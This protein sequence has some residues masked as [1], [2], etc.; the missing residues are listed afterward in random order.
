MIDIQAIR[1]RVNKA[2]RGQWVA[3]GIGSE[4]YNIRVNIHGNLKERYDA[5]G[6]SGRI[7]ETRSGRDWQE[8]RANAEFIVHARED[9]PNAL[10]EIERLRDAL[11]FYANEEKHWRSHYDD[12]C[13]SEVDDDGGNRARQALAMEGSDTQCQPSSE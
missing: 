7:A 12:M 2:T 4:G 1:E 9:L 11:K 8:I 5:I 10:D 3:E 6:F 13:M